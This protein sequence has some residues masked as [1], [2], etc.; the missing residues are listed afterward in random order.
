QPLQVVGQGDHLQLTV[1]AF[2]AAASCAAA[3]ETASASSPMRKP[4]VPQPSCLAARLQAE[5]D[6]M[7]SRG[8][9][10]RWP[11]GSLVRLATGVAKKSGTMAQRPVLPR[12]GICNNRWRHT[13]TARLDP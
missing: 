1:A 5:Q 2:P 4:F 11:R 9:A 7:I 12:L 8:R 6:G 13:M 10:A 3:P